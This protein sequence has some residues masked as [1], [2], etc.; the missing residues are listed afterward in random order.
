MTSAATAHTS[1]SRWGPRTG[2]ARWQVSSMLIPGLNRKQRGQACTRLPGC[3]GPSTADPLHGT[4]EHSHRHS[5]CYIT[6]IMQLWYVSTAPHTSLVT[7]RAGPSSAGPSPF[8]LVAR[9]ISISTQPA[10]TSSCG[11][12][13]PTHASMPGPD[14]RVCITAQVP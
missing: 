9:Q 13:Q 5:S 7:C 1:E 8:E 3:V 10:A 6:S 11:L 12:K 2:S 14:A 4:R